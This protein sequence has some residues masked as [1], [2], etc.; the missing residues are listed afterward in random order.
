ADALI[1]R[2]VERP[3]GVAG[4]DSSDSPYHVAGN[5]PSPPPPPPPPPP[6]ADLI[7]GWQSEPVHP[8]P[9]DDVRVHVWGVAPFDCPAVASQSV[10]ADLILQATLASNPGCSDTTRFWSHDFDLGQ[11]PNGNYSSLILIHVDGDTLTGR[12]NYAIS[13]NDSIPGPPAPPPPPDDSL[14]ATLSATKPNPFDAETQFSVS[15][16]DPIPAEVSIYDLLGRRVATVFRGT[17]PAGTSQLVWNGRREDGAGAPGGLSFYRLVM[18]GRVVSRR[19]VRLS[20]G[21]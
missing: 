13:V 15:V 19:V 6:G 8:H 4:P 11:L 21:N 14:K 10:G 18:P 1:R 20:P 16:Q 5:G 17:L 9:G 7:E 3:D 2:A 12:A